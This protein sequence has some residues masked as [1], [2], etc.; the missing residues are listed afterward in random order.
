MSGIH[1]ATPKVMVL[2]ELTAIENELLNGIKRQISTHSSQS[3]FTKICV[4]CA[5]IAVLVIERIVDE[6]IIKKLP[7]RCLTNGYIY[8]KPKGRLPF[9]L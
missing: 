9:G 1:Y 3:E 7:R 2:E 6:R 4:L 5:T 8:K